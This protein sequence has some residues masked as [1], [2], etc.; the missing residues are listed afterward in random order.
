MSLLSLP[1]LSDSLVGSAIWQG[2]TCSGEF[3]QYQGNVGNSLK[4]NSED[5]SLSLIS[6]RMHMGPKDHGI[7]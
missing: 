7:F 4:L 3:Q 2:R 5:I 6:G 1:G